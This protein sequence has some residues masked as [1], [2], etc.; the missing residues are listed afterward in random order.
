[1]LLSGDGLCVAKDL[2]APDSIADFDD[3]ISAIFM[4]L[5]NETAE[6]SDGSEGDFLASSDDLENLHPTPDDAIEAAQISDDVVTTAPSTHRLLEP[7]EA[8]NASEYGANPKHSIPIVEIDVQVSVPAILVETL[9]SA[10]S[11]PSSVTSFESESFELSKRSGGRVSRHDVPGEQVTGV[12][13]LPDTG[14]L[15]GAEVWSGTES[16]IW[17]LRNAIG[18]EGVDWDVLNI[19]GTSGTLTINAT[20]NAGDQFSIQVTGVNAGGAIGF[21]SGFDATK[22]HTWRLVHTENGILGFNRESFVLSTANWTAGGNPLGAGGFIIDL[23]TDAKDLLLRFVPTFPTVT[24]NSSDSTVPTLT[25]LGPDRITG[26]LNT[27]VLPDNAVIGAINEVVVHPGKPDLAF[28]GSVNG[29]VW[30]STNFSASAPA[31]PTWAPITEQLVSL[32]ISDLALSPYDADGV[33][34]GAGTS[35]NKL[36]L[37]AGTGSLSSAAGRGGSA[38]GIF[39]SLDGGTNWTEVGN[40]DGLRVTS[41]AAS[42]HTPNLVLAATVDLTKTSGGGPGRGGL[43]LS[44]NNGTT[45]YRLSGQGT[46]PE[47]NASDLVEDPSTAGRF[48]V[49]LAS[50]A[51]TG[52]NEQGIWR[53][54]NATANP[55]TTTI[56][57][58]RLVTGMTLN[59]DTNGLDDDGDTVVDEPNEG[60]DEASRIRLAVSSSGASESI[61]AALLSNRPTVSGGTGL[62]L[63]RVYRTIDQG[64]NWTAVPAA[65][66]NAPAPATNPTGQAFNH[67]AI[68]VDPTNAA[69]VYVAGAVNSV[70]PFYGIAFRFDGATWTQITVNQSVAIGPGAFNSAPHGD[71]RRLLFTENGQ[72]LIAVSDGGIYRLKNPRVANV[73]PVWEY[74]GGGLRISE[75]SHSIAYDRV[76]NAVFGGLQDNATVRQTGTPNTWASMY[77]FGDGNYMAVDYNPAQPAQSVRYFMSNNFRFFFSQIF[78]GIDNSLARTQLTLRAGAS[79]VNFSGLDNT[80]AILGQQTDQAFRGFDHIP[81]AT[82]AATFGRLLMGRAGLYESLDGGATLLAPLNDTANPANFVSALAYGG[83]DGATAKPSVVFVARAGQIAY[84]ADVSDDINQQ[85]Q[86]VNPAGAVNIRRIVLNPTNWKQAYALDASHLWKLTVKDD[87]SLEAADITGNLSFLTNSFES[88]EI[89]SQGSKLALIVGARDGAYKLDVSPD[90]PIDLTRWAAFGVGMPRVAVSDIRFDARDPGDPLDDVLIFGTLG[91]GVWRMENAANATFDEPLLRI[92]GTNGPDVFTLRLAAPAANQLPTLEILYNSPTPTVIKSYPL[93]SIQGISVHTRGGNDQ[94][95]VD[96]TNGELIFEGGIRFDGGADTGGDGDKLTFNGPVSSDLQTSKEGIHD[97]IEV[98]QLGWQI[99]KASNVETYDQSTTFEDIYYFFRNIWDHI[100]DF[101]SASESLTSDLP[102]FGDNLGGALDG[103]PGLNPPPVGQ[104]LDG[105]PTSKTPRRQPA[106]SPSSLMR[107]IFESGNGGFRIDDVGTVLATEAQ[108]EAALDALDPFGGNVDIQ[109]GAKKII[110][111]NATHPFTRTIDLQLPL[112]VELLGG[113]IKLQGDLQLA[114]DIELRLEM[115]VDARGFYLKTNATPEIAITNLRVSGKLQGVGNFGFLRIEL[116]DAVLAMDNQLKITLDLQE[117]VDPF[118]HAPD[119]FLR[120]YEVGS[121]ISDLIQVAFTGGPA[122]DLSFTAKVSVAVGPDGDTPFDLGT[123]DVGFIWE[124]ITDLSSLRIDTLGN[125]VVDFLMR[126]LNLDRGEFL[127]G[128]LSLIGSLGKL[129]QTDLLNA[130]LPFTN[131]FKL[132]D[133]FDFA[134]GFIDKIYLQLVDICLVGDLG[135]G[136]SN[137]NLSKGRLSADA[138]FD[139]TIGSQL[140]FAGTTPV[141]ITVTKASTLGNN[142]TSDLAADINSSLASKGL[143]A[144]VRASVIRGDIQL[145]LL[146]GAS[147]RIDGFDS[148]SVVATELGFLAGQTGVE[149]PRFRYLQDMLEQLETALDPPGLPDINLVVTYQQPTKSLLFG[150]TFETS[151][152]KETSFKGDSDLGL[153]ELADLSATG[154]FSIN[155]TLSI[156]GKLGIEF[157]SITTP[158]LVSSFLIPAPAT[159]QLSAPAAFTIVLN[160]GELRAP[161]SLTAVHY[162]GNISIANLVADLNG[163]LTAAPQLFQG[164]PLDKV[165]RFL[166]AGTSIHLIALNETDANNNGVLEITEDTNGDGIRQLWLDKV[167]G[168]AIDADATNTAVTELGFIPTNTARSLIKGVFVEDLALTGSLTV[169]AL[170]LGAKARFAVFSL[171][172]SGGTATGTASITLALK[173]PVDATTRIDVSKLFSDIG[174]IGNYIA[175]S[176]TFSGNL[177]IA[178]KNIKVKPD[179]FDPFPAN[180][181]VTLFIPDIKSLEFN[182]NPYHP[183]TNKLGIFV[184]Y[185]ELHGLGNFSCL[186]FLD[187]VNALDGLSDQLEEMRGFGF[188]NQPIPLINIS[189]GDILDFA[190]DLADTVQGLATG[191]GETLKDIET[192]LESLFGLGPDVL[193]FSVEHTESPQIAGGIASFNPSGPKNALRFTGPNG[194]KIKFVADDGSQLSADTNTAASDWNVLDQVLTIYF[195]AGYTTATTVDALADKGGTT[196]SLDAVAEPGSGPGAINTTVLNLKLA[197]S[198]AYGNLLPLQLSL[199][200]LVNLL[201]A[202]PTKDALFGITDFVQIEGSATINVT[203]SADLSFELGLDVSN[204]CSWVPFVDDAGTQMS[205][206]AAV[207]GTDLD[208]KIALGALGIFVKDGTVT[209][210]GDGDPLTTNDNATFGVGLKDNNGDGRHY[211]RA[212]ESWF[213]SDNI[214]ITLSAQASARLPLYFPTVS[215]PAG[216]SATDGPDSNSYPD[217]W[218]TIDVIN[219][220]TLFDALV[221]GTPMPNGILTIHTPNLTSFFDD[222]N[223]C[224]LITNSSLLLDGLD[225]F[226]GTIQSALSAEVFDRDLPLVGDKLGKAAD[227]IGEFR[228]GLLADLRAKLAEVGDPIGLVKEAIFNALG[229][230]GLDILTKADGTALT[231]FDQIDIQCTEDAVSFNLR[232]KKSVA[233]V[234]TSSD[235]IN[236]DIGIP[237]FGLKVNGNVKIEVGFDFKLKFAISASNGFYFDTSDNEELRVEFKVTIPGLSASGELLFLQLDV[238]DDSDGTDALGNPRNPSSFAGYFSINIKDPLGSG[239][240]LTFADLLS[241]GVAF[242]DVIE[243]ELG[244]IAE[245][246]LDFAVSFAGDA[247][248]PR[249]IGEFDLD[250]NWTL[251]GE[252]AGDLE[253]GFN[254]IQID[255]GSF[256]SE[257]IQPILK[258]I[259]K[260]TEPIQPL[261]DVITTPIPIIS[262]LFGE[263]ITM[264]DLAEMSGY[265]SPSTVEFIK[266]IA[267]IIDL[268][269]NTSFSNGSIL[270]PLGSFNLDLDSSGNVSRKAGDPDPAP[271]KMSDKTTDSGAKNFLQDL[272]D[273]G[274]TFPFLSISE[275]FKLFMGKPISI[276]EYHMPV[277]EFTA[278]IDFQIPIFPPLY[279]VFGGSIGAKID[280]TFGYDTYGLQK[281]FASEDKNPLDIFDGFYVKDVDN[282]GNE[283]TEFTLSGG[284]TAGAEINIGFAEFGIRGGL[285]AEIEFDLNDPDDDGKVRVSELVALALEDIRCIFDIHGRIYVALEAYLT[286]DLFFFS[287]DEVWRFGEITLA[288][289]DIVCPQP[290]LADVDG[291]GPGT[292]PSGDPGVLTLHMG[293]YASL[294]E[295]GN[296]TDGAEQ[297]TVLH[298]DGAPGEPDGESVEVSF[299]GIKQTFFGVKSI[300]V[301]AGVGNDRLDL[302]GVLSPAN[303]RGGAGSDTLFAG[304]A[305]TGNQFYGDDGNDVIT[306]EEADDGFDGAN[307]EFHGGA[308]EDSLI[309]NEGDDTL[310]GD[311]GEDTLQGNTG[312]DILEGGSGNDLLYG[313]EGIDTL[314]G[315]DG[316]DELEGHDDGDFLYGDGGNDR[317]L[318]GPGN[319]QIVGGDGDDV[320]DA[321]IGDDI[322]LGDNGVI[323]SL[324]KATGIVGTGDDVIAGGAGH[325]TL[326][327]ADGEDQIFGGAFLES[328][329]SSPTAIDGRDFIDAGLGNDLVFADDAHSSQAVVMPGGTVGDLA[330]FDFNQD[331][332]RDDNDQ[333]LAGVQVELR[334]DDNSLV[335]TTTTDSVGAYKFTGLL[336]GKYYVVF[337]KPTGLQYTDPDQGSDDEKDSDANTV[338][339]RSTIFELTTGNSNLTVDVGY[340]GSLPT[341]SIDDV[342]TYEGDIGITFMTFT[343]SLSNAYSQEVSVCYKS[344]TGIGDGDA[345]RILDYDSVDWTLI[346]APGETQKQINVPIHG[347][348]IDELN[349]VFVVTLCD[350]NNG[351]IDA[352][353]GEGT[354]TIIDDD[355]APIISILEGEQI[356]ALDPIPE[357]TSVTFRVRLSH[358]SF[359]PIRVDWKTQQI[360]NTDGTLKSDSARVFDDYNDANEY[361]PATITFLPGQTERLITVTTKADL[362]DEYGERF[363]VVLAI[364]DTTP[365]DGATMGDDVGVGIIADDDLEPYVRIKTLTPQPVDEGHAGNKNVRLEV[366]L[367]APSGR[368]VTVQWKTAT[369]TALGTPTATEAADYVYKFETLVFDEGVTTL[370]TNAQIIGDTDLEPNEYFFANLL[371][372]NFG[373][374]DTDILAFNDNH[375]RIEIANDEV[376][377]PGPWYVEFSHPL[378]EVTEGQSVTITLVRAAGSSHPIAVYWT[379][380]KPNVGTATP[381]LDYTDESGAPGIWEDG[382][383]GAGGRGIVRF[384]DGETKKTF[385]IKALSDSLYE[386]TEVALLALANPTGGN[387]RAPQ[388]LAALRILDAQ[389]GPKLSINDPI[390]TESN[391]GT[392]DVTFTVTASLDAGIS[393]TQPIDVKWNTF[394]GTA[395]AGTDFVSDNDLLTI[396]T[397]TTSTTATFKVKVVGDVTAE[398]QEQFVARLS[399]AVNAEIS[400]Y[401][402]KATINDNDRQTITGFV[403]NDL[404]G[405]GFFDVNTEYGLDGVKITVTD[406]SGP[407]AVQVTND[408]NWSV[409]VLLGSIVVS[410]DESTTPA[411]SECTTH[412]N[413]LNTQVTPTVTSTKS[414]GFM[415][416]PTKGKATANTASGNRGNNDT[417]YGG[418]G[419]DLIDGGN[420][421]DWLVGGHWLGPGCACDGKPYDASLKNQADEEGGH[422]YVD[423][424]TLPAFGTIKGR[425]WRDSNANGIQDEILLFT[426]LKEVQ[427]NLF[428]ES[429]NL[430]G[431]TYTDNNGNY[432]FAKVAPC[433]YYVQFLPPAEYRFTAQDVGSNSADSDASPITGITAMVAINGNTVDLD[434]GL[435]STPNNSN[436][437]WAIY[438]DH[439]LYSVRESDGFATIGLNRVPNSFEPVAVY[440]TKDGDFQ[441]ATLADPDYKEAKGT[442]S[443]GDGET[444]LSFV[445][446]VINDTKVEGF[447]VVLL[448]LKDPTGGDVKGRPNLARLLIFDNPCPDDDEI[449]G[450]DGDDILLGDFGYFTDAGNPELLG[451]LGNDVLMGEDGIDRIYGE[452]GN[453]TLIGGADDDQLEGGGENDTYQFDGDLNLGFDTIQEAVSPFGGNDTIDLSS[454]TGYAIQFDLGSVAVQNPTPLLQIKLPAGNVIENINGGARNDQLK[455]N[456][457]DNILRGNGGNDILEGLGGNDELR[458]GSGDDLYLFDA[459]LP[460]GSDKVFEA[461][462]ADTDR[463]DF[464]STTTQALSLNLDLVTLQVVSPTLSLKLSSKTGIEDL[465][466]GSQNDVLLGNARDNFIQGA[467]GSDTLDGGAG[468][469]V[470]VENRSGNFQ[471]VAL[472]AVTGQLTLGAE[473]NTFTLA[474]FEEISLVGDDSPNTLDASAFNGIVRLDGRGGNDTILGGTGINFLS[475]GAGDDTIIGLGITTLIEERDAD[476]ILTPT[477]LKVGATEV[478]TL[479]GITVA[480]LAGGDSN[481]VLDASAFNLP[482]T[483][484]TLDGAGGDDTLIGSPG[485]DLLIGGSG[486]DSLSGRLGDDRYGFKTQLDLGSDTLNE[487]PGEGLDTL[488]FTGSPSR[489]EANLGIDVL[490]TIN[491]NLQIRL[492]AV[493]TFENLMGGS[494]GDRLIGN[495]GPNLIQGGPGDDDLTGLGGS[496]TFE[497]GTGIDQVMEQANLNMTLTNLLLAIGLQLD[498]LNSVEGAELTGGA[499]NNT[500]DAS[501]FTLGNVTLNGDAGNDILRGGTKLDTLIGGAGDDEL[502][503]GPGSDRYVFDLDDPLGVDVIVDVSG[504]FDTLDFSQTSTNGLTINLASAAAQIVTPGRLQ[505]TLSSSN[506]IENA[507]GGDLNDRLFGNTLSNKLEGRAGNDLLE[508]FAGNDTLIGGDGNDTYRFDA[509]N[510]LGNDTIRENVGSGGSD[511]LD[512]ST[513]TAAIDV[514]LRRGLQQTVVPGFLTLRFVY[515]HNIENVIGG[516]GADTLI[517]NSLD[518]TFEGN[519]GNDTM[520]GH[521]GDDTYLFDADVNIG[522]DTVIEQPDAEGGVDVLDYSQTNVV[523]ISVNLSQANLQVVAATHSLNL[524]WPPADPLAA[525]AFENLIGGGGSDLLVGNALSNS[526]Q[527]NAG[528]DTLVGSGRADIL[529]GGAGNDI[530]NGESGNDTYVFDADSPNGDDIITELPANGTD[531]LDFSVTESLAVSVDLTTGILQVVNANQR[532]Q[533]I[534]PIA[535]ENVQG[536]SGND[537]LVSNSRNNVLEGG[538]GNDTYVFDGDLLLGNDTVIEASHPSGGQDTLDFSGTSG[539]AIKLN[540]GLELPQLVVVDFG[541]P[542]VSHLVLILASAQS[543]ENVI[544]GALK[545]SLVGNDLDNRLTGGLGEDSLTGKGGQD[546]VV[547]TRDAD[548]VLSNTA[549]NIGGQNDSLFS[550]EI[551]ELTG[552]AS[553]NKIDASTFGLGPVTFDGGLG[554]DILIGS[555]NPNDKVVA[556]RDAAMVLTDL[557]LKI[558]LEIDTISGIETASLTGG[559]S[560]NLLDASAF[561]LGPVELHG[562]GGVDSLRG[563]LRND[564]LSGGA[565]NDLLNGGPGI[566]T[567]LEQRNANMVLTDATL[568]IAGETDTLLSIERAQLTGGNAPNQ[569]DASAATLIAVVLDGAGGPDLLRGGSLNDILIGGAGN[570]SLRGGAGKDRYQFD[571]DW[572]QDTVVELIGGGTDTLDFSGVSIG[573]QVQIGSDVSVQSGNNSLTSAGTTLEGAIGSASDDSFSASPNT[574]IELSLNAGSGENDAL[575]YD[576]MGVATVQTPTTL[577]TTGFQAV[578]IAGFDGVQIVNVPEPAEA[579]SAAPIE[580]L[581]QVPQRLDDAD[582]ST[583]DVSAPENTWSFRLALSATAWRSSSSISF[584]QSTSAMANSSLAQVSFPSLES[585]FQEP[586]P[587]QVLVAKRIHRLGANGRTS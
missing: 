277:F 495:A 438:F 360:V 523:S 329:T 369:G 564:L 584:I 555:T 490:Q 399:D 65:P 331:G 28:L 39:R 117:G 157:G 73:T 18:T 256:I 542:I 187:V 385:V 146:S 159:G 222:F 200:D 507:I 328:G 279:A 276:I 287:I 359:Q 529:D 402:G 375:A 389:K 444:Y 378:Y 549:L 587:N 198:I 554:S 176:A 382:K 149:S 125:P 561:T 165:L 405:N 365:S 235:P 520:T 16:Y 150:I 536:G 304:R 1:M 244:A 14:T 421:N 152:S 193:T 370:I 15:S 151:F 199:G 186:T 163:R 446:P 274:F 479:S 216:G 440:F 431:I 136:N 511:T 254:N 6:I 52:A 265:L 218:L 408:G 486:D 96:S 260:V 182:P 301:K 91:R 102:L 161:I 327:G 286:I 433:N 326:F 390:I 379:L 174:N 170:G 504:V 409:D 500:L 435:I 227:V 112:D 140:D 252:G 49:A 197:Y 401:E 481:N 103:Q 214:D 205:L 403:F 23:S 44:P 155:A 353:Q 144:K 560:S 347:D 303:V 315:G 122:P 240:R 462:N 391:A 567:V 138:D 381:G 116:Q 13:S 576:S 93:D 556:V 552:G 384:G 242:D 325:D 192:T 41:I 135:G 521:G 142:S 57:F 316:A 36:V 4:E 271:S 466:G 323:V 280:L 269:N 334:R 228:E 415:V 111:G 101:F 493:D 380:G 335:G 68:A 80:I 499:G 72:D 11:P 133:A 189:V 461:A 26:N 33:L 349:E 341:I 211:F 259:Q 372:A 262:D 580:I 120:V 442:V 333:G 202:G 257:F 219:L 550:I 439:I 245:L 21:A 292:E 407:L 168:I 185:P 411:N 35:V 106:E 534:S 573:I 568:V 25:E 414:M 290:V 436:G 145:C 448:M 215:L 243:A 237:G 513:T 346:F 171:E 3:S 190:G 78:T 575:I 95:I 396:P 342:S 249:L 572:G 581:H 356:T 525:V 167:N 298:I 459:D 540:L 377:D 283:I 512:F 60:I 32:A 457:L 531:T 471:L 482:G 130:E 422:R 406:S 81:F 98:R 162:G 188:L 544:G 226:L 458:G 124:D 114:A 570:D 557:D 464:S 532:I 539:F 352:T 363:N 195:N 119:G 147:I 148:S 541:P 351:V 273:L 27:R 571:D 184:T 467:A 337:K 582:Q 424:A 321:G 181:E 17:D 76:H 255:I 300:I 220:G 270:I 302:R 61:Y 34:L 7:A 48:Y 79:L 9:R 468:Y 289:F 264:L 236:F 410:A 506:S 209:L 87:G 313:D 358:P 231:S 480:Q 412:N 232:L 250:W 178:L 92:E 177:S 319:D 89:V 476:F 51:A 268:V 344:S 463:I 94:L 491:A 310:Y 82:N 238:S 169:S 307:D 305:L 383:P 40:F 394:A 229:K 266:A 498:S 494:G 537:V 272:E 543:I 485:N 166:Q 538:A 366:S 221:N 239:N 224:D 355:D 284:I 447:E 282:D 108:I 248:F 53:T 397:F 496:D 154:K 354:G 206:N 296:T 454:T 497:G 63:T 5:T 251:G 129:D 559:V 489:V 546:T 320:I 336:P 67:F 474:S 74:I 386:G 308:G 528:A 413:P 86:A 318:G 160:D 213:D 100:V 62:A 179:L 261:I 450:R 24:T 509:D 118:G 492:S 404:N 164:Q 172:T 441:P 85:F 12:T 75:V 107:R 247:R 455:G 478:D 134:Q 123:L 563:G 503:G 312:D 22:S 514:D 579:A 281:F 64:N 583:L 110:L 322:V 217:N 472:D 295:H 432:S 417:A 324:L 586:H 569:L 294:R 565:G 519:G 233:L 208:F 524:E 59:V 137:V 473:V 469:D 143:G 527:G 585:P 434:A 84:R 241:S 453:D 445:V 398:L 223:V 113:S 56:N 510:L 253:F 388:R 20:P 132:A 508:G 483:R 400:D 340:K 419:N 275:L 204:P 465:Y 577:H 547:E 77:E 517:G 362:L 42:R 69:T 373:R 234:D 566:D 364:N 374:I 83:F 516:S 70:S 46:L 420:G 393:S 45:W 153:G 156:G 502:R 66:P 180:A 306:G 376:P 368:A 105:G 115:G 423:P 317:I 127:D 551:A 126:F 449:H 30:K 297:F 196:I 416:Q 54:D 194:A 477:Q 210:D 371:A 535:L 518:N 285:F 578:Q 418:G 343:V 258:E 291:N 330:W 460:L 246:N 553:P 121:N 427:I 350:P 367:D 345:K 293:E 392:T 522:S 128:V 267:K 88:L 338:T 278:S 428:D 395:L 314:R 109:E 58:N 31:G 451:G 443:F 43:Y 452:G 309:G 99:V 263:P 2:G 10:N 175:P 230:P 530:L 505:L 501:A 139:L 191:D 470:L 456:S 19:T 8:L 426:A 183:V 387:P 201:P 38:A 50:T 299:N 545:D 487:L 357:T 104:P 558:G 437:P 475:G 533:L 173:N 339:G 488:D 141:K 203:A 225:T 207:R 548:I 47:V 158:K 574:A 131:G 562:E 429:W 348:T 37:F 29:G 311:D 425:V 526:I 90:Q 97:E 332:F 484:V 515:C 71:F 361:N 430:V 55:A 212:S 288:E